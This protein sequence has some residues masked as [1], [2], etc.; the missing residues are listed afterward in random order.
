MVNVLGSDHHPRE[1]SDV[2][3]EE[4]GTLTGLR[5]EGAASAIPIGEV[6]NL[7]GGSRESQPGVSFWSYGDL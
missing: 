2:R 7:G 1:L 3:S 4:E 6:K 5:Q